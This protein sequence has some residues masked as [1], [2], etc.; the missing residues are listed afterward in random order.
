MTLIPERLEIGSFKGFSESGLELKAEVIA[1]FSEYNPRI[2]DFVLVEI[3][4]ESSVVGRI[5]K[6][7]PEGILSSA[8][9]DE[10]LAAM[11]RRRTT[12]PSDVREEKLRYKVSMKLLGNLK[13]QKDGRLI[14]AASV[15]TLP[16]LGSRVGRPDM[17]VVSF[18]CRLGGSES[19]R[20][21][22]EP[23]ET[24]AEIGCF[25]VGDQTTYM[26]Q[27][28]P[29]Y[30]DVKNLIAKRT[31]VFA[32]AGFGKSNFVKLL[33]AKLYEKEQRSGMLIFDPE[34]EYAFPTEK[35]P[36]LFSI[37]EIRDKL[38]IYTNRQMGSPMKDWVAGDVKI[39]MAKI[40]P[41]QAVRHFLPAE[42]QE[43]NFANALRGTTQAEWGELV[44]LFIE[45][46]FR[47]DR[48]EVEDLVGGF[49]QEVSIDAIIYNF[50]PIVRRVH[51]DDSELMEEVKHHLLQG[52][53]VVVDISTVSSRD[54]RELMGL[55]LSDIFYH[56]QANFVSGQEGGKELMDVIAVVEEAQ[57][58][59]PQ[60]IPESS[61]MVE[62]VKEGRKY[63][64]GSI[65]IT[66]QPGAI[67]RELVSQGDNFF[68]FH[69]LSQTDARSLQMHNA[70][71]S[72]DVLSALIHEPIIGNAFFWSAP[73]Q[74]F[75][76]SCRIG[77][78]EDYVESID[79]EEIDSSRSP[80]GTF[81]SES[82]SRK[83][84]F[85]DIV[86]QTIGEDIRC[87]LYENVLVNGNREPDMLAVDRWNLLFTTAENIDRKSEIAEYYCTCFPGGDRTYAMD[88]KVLEVLEN[89][90]ILAI[91]VSAKKRQRGRDK[92]FYL[93]KAESCKLLLVNKSPSGEELDLKVI[94]F[95]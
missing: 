81:E 67:A 50:V 48:K 92:E 82:Q 66:Q 80:V 52:R 14:F 93:L 41:S 90:D 47:V 58:V 1:P 40:T 4:P 27:R 45:N 26:N 53:V 6:F 62:W 30:F 31:F 17:D 3:T 24:D 94:D 70:H 59:L 13:R 29:T 72:D 11:A 10:Y 43:T 95:G 87:K 60:N 23:G 46:G 85:R 42:K 86:L 76:M 84:G 83:K 61:P 73:R 22:S 74:P 64:L 18:L 68:V 55:L 21:D 75:V 36:A 37:P 51:S 91:R 16:H 7:F 54:G 19:C 88:E 57:S 35:V 71:F 2:G 49:G 33:I 25:A 69:L 65:L 77:N 8:P 56:N 79:P 15:R 20:N 89:E 39:N 9:G 32:K 38:I 78:F 44:R 63:G 34:G 28:I 5:V 12:I